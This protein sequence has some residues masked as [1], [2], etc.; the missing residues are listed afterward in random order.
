MIWVILI[1]LLVVLFIIWKRSKKLKFDSV[2]MVNGCIGSGKTLLCVNRAKRDFKKAHAIWWRRT[3]IYSIIFKKLKNEEEPLLYSN[4]PIYSNKKNLE[5]FK[6]YVPL[7]NDIIMR[8]KRVRYHSVMLWD[9]SSLMATSMDYK[10]K[11]LSE[12]MSL[13]LKLLRHECKG[14]Y[15][16]IF[17]SHAN[18]YINT[19]SKNDNHYA[20][21]RIVNQVLYITKSISIPFFKV[22]WVRDL[23]LIDSVQNEFNDDIKESLSCRWFLIPKKTFNMYDSYS[24]EFLSHDFP[25]ADLDSCPGRIYKVGDKICFEIAT[26]HEWQEIKKSNAMLHDLIDKKKEKELKEN[27]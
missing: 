26:F 20:V 21:D 3:H 25:V 6:Y 14:S 1:V 17:G 18:L 4:I 2:V 22:V 10:Q 13:F 11:D 7:T 16:N 24:Y 9:E 27:G 23:L 15:R 5:L 19:Q 12:Q 8:K